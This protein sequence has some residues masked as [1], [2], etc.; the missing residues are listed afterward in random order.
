VLVGYSRFAANQFPSANYSFHSFEDGPGSLRADAVLKAGE[1]KF[2]VDD[3]G[4]NHWGDWSATVVDPVNDTDL[5]TIQEYG[6]ESRVWQRPLG[7]WWGR[8]SLRVA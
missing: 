5:W 6:R 3:F 2:F 8:V 4:V 7:T 1:A